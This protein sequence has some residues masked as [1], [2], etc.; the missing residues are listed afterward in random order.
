MM[1]LSRI[2]Y[3][4]A[5]LLHTVFTYTIES[6]GNIKPAIEY[7]IT[8][9]QTAMVRPIHDV[10]LGL[11]SA[12]GY[13]AMY[14]SDV[15]KPFLTRFITDLLHLPNA[16][17]AGRDQEPAFI[18]VQPGMEQKYDIGYDPLHRC[19]DT[20][21]P[22]FWAKDTAYIFLCPS[23]T[24]LSSQPVFTPGGPKDIY[25]PIVQNNVFLGQSDPLVK[26]QNYDLI[27]QLV[28]LYLQGEALT[29]ETIPKEV[30]DWNGCVGL[31]WVPLEG[32]PSVR[33]PFNL[34]YYVACKW[35]FS[36]MG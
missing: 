6:C 13:A 32:S 24:T 2:L 33:N 19:T 34:V 9:A 28:H 29:S 31:G 1:K 3:S 7:A 16:H 21:V 35:S 14:K 23:F 22:S 5:L 26:Y 36:G 8:L 20:G 27:H 18:C 30:T 25:C 4:L 11:S 10:Q 12:H 17:A 15:F